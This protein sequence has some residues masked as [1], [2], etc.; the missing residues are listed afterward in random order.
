MVWKIVLKTSQSLTQLK[1]ENILYYNYMLDND[2][3]LLLKLNINADFLK[4]LLT[5]YGSKMVDL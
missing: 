2:S 5:N 4:I 1:T 3:S